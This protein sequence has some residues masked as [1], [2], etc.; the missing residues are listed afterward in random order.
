MQSECREEM[1]KSLYSRLK[2]IGLKNILIF[3]NYFFWDFICSLR[4]RIT[5]KIFWRQSGLM[6]FFSIS[7]DDWYYKYSRY[8]YLRFSR[9]PSLSICSMTLQYYLD[10]FGD[11]STCPCW[12][13]RLPVFKISKTF[14]GQ[15]QPSCHI[16]IIH[17]SLTDIIY[18]LAFVNL[19]AIRKKENVSHTK[20]VGS[21]QAFLQHHSP[22]HSDT[23]LQYKLLVLAR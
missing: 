7:N 12:F 17:Q 13:A 15:V 20:R 22:K 2:R 1:Y 23:Q 14:S 16:R 18:L 3:F 10:N 4:R 5:S 21:H 19:C 6:R 8:G 11:S 9:E